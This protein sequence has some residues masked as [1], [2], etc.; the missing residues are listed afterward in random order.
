MLQRCLCSL[1][2]VSAAAVVGCNSS[3]TTK[4]NTTPTNPGPAP[5]KGG[6]R[7]APVEKVQDLPP[8]P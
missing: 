7:T 6:E 4:P 5:N 1:L 8:R 3:A 2:L